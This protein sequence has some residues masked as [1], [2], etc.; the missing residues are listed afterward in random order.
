MQGWMGSLLPATE[1]YYSFPTSSMTTTAFTSNTY[2]STQ[3]YLTS[4]PCCPWPKAP[5]LTAHHPLSI[6]MSSSGPPLAGVGR[7]GPHGSSPANVGIPWDYGQGHGHGFPDDPAPGTRVDLPPPPDPIPPGAGIALHLGPESQIPDHPGSMV[8]VPQVQP[9]QAY[10]PPPPAVAPPPQAV[11]AAAAAGPG[12]DLDMRDLKTSCQVG[13]RELSGMQRL[14]RESGGAAGVESR[15]RAQA[16]LVLGDLRALQDEVRGLV[17]A[18]EDHRWRR[19]I[20]GG[21][22]ATFIPAVRRIFRRGGHDDADA[23][24]RLSSNGT[25][26]AFRRSRGLMARIK[27]GVLGS[28]SLAK[29]AFF[30]FAVLY[31][32]QNEVSLRVARTVQKRVRRLMERVERG[33][34]DVGEKDV[35]MLDGWRWRVLLW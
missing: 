5:N 35:R 28:G 4:R 17:K 18:A 26:Y 30:V 15:I 1:Y 22:I 13:L 19:W 23:D 27:D 2:T 34:E 29:M 11:T 25:E 7:P 32:F 10:Y 21:L 16:G 3:R 12:Q 6:I 14:R 8:G 20:F 9:P 33:D 24:S 31:V